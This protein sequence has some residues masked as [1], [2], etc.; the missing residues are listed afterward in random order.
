MGNNRPEVTWP[1]SQVKVSTHRL[2][3]VRPDS[4][5]KPRL[6]PVRSP[7]SEYLGQNTS[8]RPDPTQLDHL[9]LQDP[10]E[11]GINRD[12]QVCM[13]SIRLRYFHIGGLVWVQ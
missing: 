9:G 8:D 3:P 10:A 12:F 4:V 2:D 11:C 6:D 7:R 13:E 5:R 1:P